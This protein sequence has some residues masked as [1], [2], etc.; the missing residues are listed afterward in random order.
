[1]NNFKENK[2]LFFILLFGLGFFGFLT[3]LMLKD[4]FNADYIQIAGIILGSL[5]GF[6]A[7]LNA[8]G[9]FYFFTKDNIWTVSL[10][11]KKENWKFFKYFP[12]AIAIV[13]FIIAVRFYQNKEKQYDTEYIEI[14]ITQMNISKIES[15]KSSK[16]ISIEAREYPK[17][18][19]QI[20]GVAFDNLYSDYYLNNIKPGDTL[21]ALITKDSY[22]KKIAQTESLTFMDKT[23]NFHFISVYGLKHKDLEL[24]STNDY[25]YAKESDSKLGVIFFIGVGLFFLYLQYRMNKEKK[26]EPLTHGI[27]NKGFS[28]KGKRSNRIKFIII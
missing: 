4:A 28:G 5:F 15:V 8:V 1:M 11:V 20:Q 13:F 7:A 24:L 18:R 3:F 19:F 25:E 6:F 17:Y 22:I 10:N 27:A 23:I 2:G 26:A 12:T 9:L 21:V 14:T 16:Y